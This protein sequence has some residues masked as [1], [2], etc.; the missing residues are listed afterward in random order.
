MQ[1]SVPD[2]TIHACSVRLAALLTDDER[3]AGRVFPGDAPVSRVPKQMWQAA[4][5]VPVQMWLG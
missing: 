1:A 2:A 5:R 3:A 4:S